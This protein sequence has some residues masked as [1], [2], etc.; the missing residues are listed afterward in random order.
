MGR[1]KPLKGK[2]SGR[3]LVLEDFRNEKGLHVCRCKCDCGNEKVVRAQHIESKAIQSCGCINIEHGIER[4]YVHGMTGTPIHKRWLA[5]RR[6]CY[7]KKLLYY[8]NYGG[9]GINVCDRWNKFENFYEDMHESFDKHVEKF[10]EKD[11]TLDRID[12]N[13]NYCK[14]NCRW[15]TRNEQ[16]MNKRNSR[17]YKFM[18]N[19]YNIKE[20]SVVFGERDSELLRCRLKNNN[21]DV[22]YVYN[23][24]YMNE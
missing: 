6:R 15:I 23:R 7:D 19:T 16:Q 14:E 3:L 10:G 13:G 2:R 9:R 1:W 20:L 4:F 17:H 12:V 11:T 22:M 8:E 21:Y 18:E 5:M 24:W